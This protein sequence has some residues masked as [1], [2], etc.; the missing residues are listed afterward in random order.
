MHGQRGSV[1]ENRVD[2]VLQSLPG[3]LDRIRRI[4]RGRLYSAEELHAKRTK[5]DTKAFIA[6]FAD[7]LAEISS[8]YA[9]IISPS[10]TNTV[11]RDELLWLTKIHHTGNIANFLPLMVAARKHRREWAHLGMQI[12]LR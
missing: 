5:A 7:G 8:Y 1:P 4:Q 6:R 12:T 10:A 9:S 11:S 3:E 2:A